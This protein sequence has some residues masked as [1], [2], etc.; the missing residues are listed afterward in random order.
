MVSAVHPAQ[1]T[2]NAMILPRFVL[3]MGTMDSISTLRRHSSLKEPFPVW[4]CTALSGSNSTKLPGIEDRS[5]YLNLV[6]GAGKPITDEGQFPVFVLGP[7][8]SGTSAMAL[9]LL[10]SG[11]YS[12]YGEGHLLPLA[13]DL[14]ATADTYY[15]RY[16]EAGADTLLGRVPIAAFQSLIRRSFVQLARDVFPTRFWLDKTP[17]VAMVHAAPLM[18]ELWPNA[19]FIFMKRR[20]IENVLS[21]LRKFPGE[22]TCYGLL[23]LGCRHGGLAR[24]ARKAD[25]RSARDRTSKPCSRP[26][27]RGIHDRRLSA[28]AR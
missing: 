6:S 4:K 19:R 23:R 26:Q 17:T 27:C 18:K 9:G 2:S 1:Q 25:R 5:K 20:V 24:C 11:R 16:A 10:D 3:A 14:L 13:H 21:R 7:A 12:G 22:T 28:D 15:R 8:R